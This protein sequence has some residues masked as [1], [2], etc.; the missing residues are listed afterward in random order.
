MHYL[1]KIAWVCIFSGILF[2]ACEPENETP[3]TGNGGSTTGGGSTTSKTN[4]FEKPWLDND[5]YVA[6]PVWSGTQNLT[7]NGT[8]SYAGVYTYENLTINDNA[9][10]YS[11]G[12]SELVL[13][14]KG[15]LKLG[16]NV[17]IQVRNGYYSGTP[18]TKASY[19]TKSGITS[20]IEYKNT[21]LL[22]S[23]YGKGGNGGNGG[24][25]NAGKSYI[26]YYSVHNYETIKGHGG[27]GGGGG[28]GGF[29]GGLS[30]SGGNGGYGPGGDGHDGNPGKANGGNGGYGGANTSIGNGG[31]ATGVGTSGVMSSDQLGAGGGGGGGNGGNGAS[32]AS[33]KAL[34]GGGGGRGG[35]GGGGGGYGGG[36]LYIA[37]KKIE[38]DSANPPKFVVCGQVGGSGAQWGANGEG[39]L[40]IIVSETNTIPDSFWTLSSAFSSVKNTGGHGTVTG[41][42]GA[43][44]V[45]GIKK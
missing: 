33:A 37:A 18:N 20:G 26:Y 11:S 36:I 13:K 28:G 45:N 3:N 12:I 10:I 35:N 32:G 15:T 5:T 41:T 17:V 29:G 7:S 22:P 6:D 21:Y 31:G 30:G 34:W 24:N 4:Y 16:K 14:V 44:F 43:V 25:G 2:S 27:S 19:I 1:R 9:H 40:L 8:Y 39:G 42:P 23:V 38:F